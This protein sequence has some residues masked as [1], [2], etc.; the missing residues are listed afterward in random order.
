MIECVVYKKKAVLLRKVWL[1]ENC[2]TPCLL[3]GHIVDALGPKTKTF[4]EKKS[5]PLQESK[6]HPH[7]DLA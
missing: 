5:R 4:V 3:L 7:W 1:S 2:Y 6:S